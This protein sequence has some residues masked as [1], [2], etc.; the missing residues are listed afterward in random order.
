MTEI[1]NIL[2]PV[3]RSEVSLRA[4]GVA[5]A[6]AKWYD[7]RLRVIE[8]VGIPGPSLG[9][10]PLAVYGLTQEVRRGLADELERFS[11]PA[12]DAGVS[13]RVS[14]EEGDVVGG[15]LH[16]A[17]AIGA[18]L[19]VI[20]THGRSGFQRLTLGSVTE[21]VL[22]RAV[23]PVLTVPPGPE[24]LPAGDGLFKRILCAVDFSMA[25]L[26]GVEFALSLAKEADAQITLVH[27]LDWPRDG[28]LPREL[29]EAVAGTRAQWEATTRERLHALVPEGAREWC[30]PEDLVIAGRPAEEIL[31]LARERAE[32]V[33]VLGVHGRGALDLALFG[34]HTHRVVREAP[35]PVLKVRTRA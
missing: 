1:R 11:A 9:P 19:I 35:C 12:R 2:C 34:S 15:I 25:S 16:E 20:G 31:R 13:V 10:A 29:E 24:V 6:L 4:L 33:I 26:K 23:C 32:E 8:V 30:T 21:K 22:R 3:D 28:L 14:V 7:A 27:V 18:D 17:E 5:T